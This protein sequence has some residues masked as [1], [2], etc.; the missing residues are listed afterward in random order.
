MAEKS[1]LPVDQWHVILREHCQRSLANF[2]R[3]AW[4]VVDPSDYIHGWHI[5][6]IAEHLEAVSRGEIKRLYIAVPPGTMK[7]L[8]TSVFWPCWEWTW[9][10][11]TRVLATSHTERLTLRDNSKSRRIIQSEWYQSLWPT[12]IKADQ[13]AKAKF[14][15]DSMGFREAMP[16]TS[17]TGSR[18]DRVIIDDPISADN[19]NSAVSR[20]AAITTFRESVQSRLTDPRKSAIVIIQ[21]RLHE[22]DLIGLVD[23]M[24]LDYEK[25]VLPMEFEPTRRCTTSIGFT[26]PRTEE[27][28][29]LFPELFPREVVNREKASMGEYAV[30]GQY[31]QRPAPR[32]GGMFPVERFG[33][34]DMPPGDKRIKSSVR[35]WDK[36]GS[37]GKGAYSAGVLMHRLKN[38]T[39]VVA[40][41][42]RG[43]W[44]ALERETRIKQT[45]EMDGKGVTVWVEQEPGSGGKESAQSTVRNLSGLN[46][47]AERV[48]GDKEKRADPYAAQVQND[49]VWLVKAPWNRAFID[50]HET[51]PAG[52]YKDQVDAAA[53]AFAKLQKVRRNTDIAGPVQVKD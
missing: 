47:H 21:Q 25:L 9:K 1:S 53:G 35:Y 22:R 51:F 26:D 31:Q 20:N 38:D 33:V 32:G 5:D 28:E 18:G 41:V 11:S 23:E 37:H 16:F 34:V 7:S 50:E 48:S 17:L 40:D 6:A 46:A 39:Y 42:V 19:S 4:P 24:A 8:L 2:V 30:A 43:Q 3:E 45:A 27:G 52:Q 12:N 15:N 13:N 29:L 49:N 36:A 10:P 14:E 44:S